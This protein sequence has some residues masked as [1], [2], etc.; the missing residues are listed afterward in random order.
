MTTSVP[1]S[2]ILPYVFYGFVLW[3][4]ID[5]GT[6]GGV[7]LSYFPA[8]GP[9]LLAFYLGYPIVF[10]FLIFKVRWYNWRLLLAT[11]LAILLIEGLFTRN[12]F[13]V[14]FPL[15]LVGIPLA[16]AIYAPL[17]YFPLWLVNNEMGKHKVMASVLSLVVTTVVLLTTFGGSS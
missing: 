8:H 2:K 11:F 12:P 1:K 9:L 16:L 4:L 3:V 5:L 13:V 17:T 6:A 7:R 15:L 14:S 10:A